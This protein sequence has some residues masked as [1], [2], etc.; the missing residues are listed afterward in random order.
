MNEQDTID[1]KDQFEALKF[2]SETQRA[3]RE[4]RRKSENQGFYTAVTFF[5]LIG[6]SKF[7]DKVE[8][9]DENRVIFVVVIWVILLS[10]ALLA[11]VY[12]EGLH[13]ANAVNRELAQNAEHRISNKL[14]LAGPTG[15]G[16]TIA[17]TRYWK[18]AT[19][20]IFAVSVGILL[21]FF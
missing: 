3:L 2:I 8:F 12:L 19:I 6:A 4:Q 7:T 1:W 14:G 17:K 20:F 5:V 13:A 11:T 9:P 18:Q 10:V 21:T 15:A 16:K